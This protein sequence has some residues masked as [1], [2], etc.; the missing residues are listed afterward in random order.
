MIHFPDSGKIIGGMGRWHE[1]N[2][3]IAWFDYP[4]GL[5][6]YWK[7][8]SML[9][10]ARLYELTGDKG[11][12]ERGELMWNYFIGWEETDKIFS[13]YHNTG[14]TQE[15]DGVSYNSSWAEPGFNYTRVD[16]AAFL[17]GDIGLYNATQNNKYLEHAEKMADN[18]LSQIDNF[19]SYYKH[20]NNNYSHDNVGALAFFVINFPDHPKS[21]IIKKHLETWMDLVVKESNTVSP[22]G[23]AKKNFIYFES[24]N[25]NGVPPDTTR[26]FFNRSEEGKAINPE[27]GLGIWQ[28]LLIHKIIPKEEYLDHALNHINWIFGVNPRDFC[29][30]KGIGTNVPDIYPGGMLDGCICHGIISDHGFDRPWLGTWI[31]YDLDWRK[32]EIAGHKIWAQGEALIRGTACFMMGLTLLP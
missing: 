11:F 8:Y 6:E 4:Y 2:G 7:F 10:Y 12:L 15:S 3:M 31:N 29:M 32:D 14:R 26:A 20:W 30:M 17:L 28:A 13:L 25:P 21:G 5:H 18:I 1:D 19:E 24:W 23:I 27:Y 22:F 9:I 16:D